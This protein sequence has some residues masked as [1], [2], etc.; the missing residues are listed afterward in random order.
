MKHSRLTKFLAIGILSAGM[1]FSASAVEILLNPIHLPLNAAS[2]PYNSSDAGVTGKLS[3]SFFEAFPDL[4]LPAPPSGFFDVNYAFDFLSL[5]NGPGLID[6]VVSAFNL[7][8]VDDLNIS[9]P[10]FGSPDT[11]KFQ[12]FFLTPFIATVPDLGSGDFNIASFFDVFADVQI[13][14]GEG[15]LDYDAVNYGRPM[16]IHLSGAPSAAPDSVSTVFLML[17]STGLLGLARRFRAA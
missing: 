5:P 7:Y 8:S 14:H 13:T 3:S 6:I 17:I 11:F 16:E 2:S 4:S 15:N 9:G 10:G 12:I 1:T